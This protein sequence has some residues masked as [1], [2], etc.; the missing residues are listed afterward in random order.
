M[1]GN[2]STSVWGDKAKPSVLLQQA[3]GLCCL[4]ADE[5]RASAIAPAAS[6]RSPRSAAPRPWSGAWLPIAGLV[7]PRSRFV[8]SLLGRTGRPLRGRRKGEFL[9]AGSMTPTTPVDWTQ[10]HRSGAT[11]Q[12]RRLTPSSAALLF[13]RRCALLLSQQPASPRSSQSAAH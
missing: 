11:R 7:P 4:A 12:G 10:R 13:D 3:G 9:T 2:P 1:P 8:L 6:P 5:P